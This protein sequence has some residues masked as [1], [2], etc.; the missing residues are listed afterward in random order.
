VSGQLHDPAVYPRGKGPG[1]H[2]IGGWVGSKTGLDDVEK[3]KF[4]TPKCEVHSSTKK[5]PLHALRSNRSAI[6]TSR[7]DKP[8]TTCTRPQHT[9]RH[10]VIR[11]KWQ[12]L[13]NVGLEKLAGRAVCLC[14]SVASSSPEWC[15]SASSCLM[16]YCFSIYCLFND[17][18]NSSHHTKSS[19]RIFREQ[20]IVKFN[21]YYRLCL[22]ALLYVGFSLLV[23]FTISIVKHWK[24]TAL[25]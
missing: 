23:S 5:E 1:T 2:W 7:N 24:E 21:G 18:L 17:D 9:L 10:A 14:T 11:C 4:L 19:D 8:Y 20:P 3:R 25:A 16:M 15:S 6:V 22:R 13:A 12:R